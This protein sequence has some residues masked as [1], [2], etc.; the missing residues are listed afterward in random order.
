MTMHHSIIP[1]SSCLLRIILNFG[2]TNL[3]LHRGVLSLGQVA[4]HSASPKPVGQTLNVHISYGGEEGNTEMSELYE[5]LITDH[6]INS[7]SL[8]VANHGCVISGNPFAFSFQPSDTFP[9]LTTLRLDGYDFDNLHHARSTWHDLGTAGLHGLRRYIADEFGYE[10]LRPKQI[11]LTIDRGSN[12]RLWKSAMD[13]SCLERLELKHVYLPTFF[14]HMSGNLP[15]IKRLALWPQWWRESSEDLVRETEDFLN[16]L[17]LLESLSLHGYT[18]RINLEGVLERYKPSLQRLELR[19]WESEDPL[20]RRPVLSQ[21]QLMKITSLCPE[22]QELSIDINRNGTWPFG[23]LSALSTL[24]NLRHLEINLE[25]GIDQHIHESSHY[26]SRKQRKIADA[27]YRQPIFN[28]ASGTELFEGLR[29]EKKGKK[30][31][32]MTVTLGD[33]GRDF[34]GGLRMTGWGEG[35]EEKWVCK[36]NDDGKEGCEKVEEGCCGCMRGWEE[37]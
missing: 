6:D 18:G 10:W 33:W 2:L 35:L 37:E 4:G 36:V 1:S 28:A 9:A 27:D 31:E 8:K 15:G 5:T 20:K 12:L 3:V 22:L 7:L 25:L 21:A 16:S 17:P 34:G 19:E 13:W 23:S 29:R 24:E 11:P 26:L 30:L 14:K 32:K